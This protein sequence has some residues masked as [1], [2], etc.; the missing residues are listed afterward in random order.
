MSEI[1]RTPTRAEGGITPE[2]LA[3]MKAHTQMWIDRAMRTDPIEPDKIIPAIKSL[4]AVAGLKE[5]RVVIVPSPRVMAF[6]GGFASAIWWLRK[7][8]GKF[9]SAATDDATH[10]ATRDATYV[11][12][13]VAT[14]NATDDATDDA[15]RA[16]TLAATL[17]ATDA[18][19]DTATEA[20]TYDATRDATDA[21]IDDATEA[22]TLDA[23]N[24]ATYAATY[25]ATRDAT[26]AAIDD[27]TEAA[28]LDAIN[29]A[30]YAATDAA[31]RAATF[32]AIDD[33]TE[34]AT[35]D[36]I[37]DATYAATYTATRAATFDATRAAT[38]AATDDARTSNAGLVRFFLNCATRWNALYQGGNMW[39]PY[40]CYL[41]ACRDILGLRLPEHEKYQAWEQC[42]IHG[43]F[44]LMHE[45]FCIVSDFPEILKKDEQNR[46]HADD[47]PSHRWRDG[48]EL[49]YWHGVQVTRQI[50]MAP[51][52]LTIEQVRKEENAEVRRVMIERMGWDRFCK[53]ADLKVIHRDTMT[54]YF[55]AIPVSETVHA[56]MRAITS[57]REGTEVAELLE[58]SE[59][60][61]F[62]NH[63]LKFVRVT[64]PSTG[65]HY[66]LRV[67]HENTRAYQ[68]V[69]QT[70]GM[71]EEEYRSSIATHS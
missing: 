8:P 58:S 53:L 31:T 16:A 15:T 4:Y 35:L 57:Y 40:D 49:Y 52:T 63:P 50:V 34:A 70:F 55:P 25:D 68:A 64:D 66:V 14:I 10:A 9:I 6:A 23:I 30:T 39:A 62:D 2:E 3:M 37:D 5:P 47:G 20:A 29:D 24:D 17:A 43:G 41:T 32:A 59:F 61:D 28:T 27:A 33:A 13:L 45:E 22:A 11:A 36:A 54:A 38:R 71:T 1:V 46:P 69:A 18:A 42:A 48:W 7:N 56:N 51:E 19:T 67:W 12:T 26:D 21:A 60:K 44:R 65:E